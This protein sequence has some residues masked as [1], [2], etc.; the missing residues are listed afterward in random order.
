MALV[1]VATGDIPTADILDAAIEAFAEHGYGGTSVRE[2]ARSLGGSHNLI[3]NRIGSKEA[4][5]Y[6]AVDHA[7]RSQYA[8]LAMTF[9]DRADQTDLTDPFERLEAL[10]ARFIEAN[11]LHPALVQ[12]IAQES[13]TPGPRLDHL[14][15]RWIEPVRLFGVDLL[16]QLR[17]AGDVIVDSVGLVYFSMTFGGAAPAAFPALAARFGAAVD[18]SDA[19]AVRRYSD[20]AAALLFRGL[21][22]RPHDA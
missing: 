20:D 13:K 14:F 19:E 22:A 2:V 3:P 12:V 17:G 9:T 8:A 15:D 21:L 5:W 11:L 4:L 7:A 6:A 18:P 10:V 1:D 16:T